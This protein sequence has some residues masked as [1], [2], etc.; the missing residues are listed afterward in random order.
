MRRVAA[1]LGVLLVGAFGG[2]AQATLFSFPDFAGVVCNGGA[3]TCNNSASIA[4][5]ADGGVL[6]LTPATDDQAGSA[7]ST[8]QVSLGAGATF[9]TFF[10]F[11]L[12]D[13]GGINPADGITF[14]LQ[15]QSNTA[16]G[17][18]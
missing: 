17:V 4:T 16:G 10:Q 18:G 6:R 14:T 13:P 11:R 9:S 15:T 2:A 3:L 5:T 12:T 7:F 1:V 8:S